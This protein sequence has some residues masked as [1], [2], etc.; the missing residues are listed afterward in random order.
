MLNAENFFISINQALKQFREYDLIQ[1]QSAYRR[2]Q[3]GKSGY[4][5][6]DYDKNLGQRVFDIT[7]K[8]ISALDIVSMGI[9]SVDQLTP[10]IR[11]IQTAL[12]NYPNLPPQ[13][14]GTSIIKKWIDTLSTK[15]ATDDLNENEIR[16]LK[17]DIDSV[18]NQF[19]DL[20]G[21]K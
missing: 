9:Q 12:G 4:K 11:D 10:Y 21:S 15:Q 14:G 20:L 18:M 6:E 2:I 16:Q 19:N 3:E 5:G 13:F 7:T 8:I 1:C 17:F